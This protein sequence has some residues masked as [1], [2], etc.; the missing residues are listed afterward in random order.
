M[1]A[2]LAGAYALAAPYSLPWYDLLAWACL[3]ALVGPVVDGAL[4]ARLA[5]M[6]AAYVPGRVLGMTAGVEALTLGVRR[7]VAPWL[8]LA[9]WAVVITSA[10]RPGWARRPGPRPPASGPPPTR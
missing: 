9:V 7:H 6:S 2:V 1:T 8:L 5:V 4:L 3:P 10:V